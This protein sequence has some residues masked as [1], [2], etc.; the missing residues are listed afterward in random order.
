LVEKKAD[1]ESSGRPAT[2]RTSEIPLHEIPC[3]GTTVDDLLAAAEGQTDEMALLREERKWRDR[4]VALAMP[5]MALLML[6][7]GIVLLFPLR[8]TIFST[9]SG[10]GSWLGLAEHPRAILG[11][12]DLVLALLL[13]LAVTTVYPILRLRL[14]AGLGYLGYFAY[15]EWA[16]GRATGLAEIF[17]LAVFSA[18]VFVCTI[19]S[20]FAVMLVSG[21]AALAA[22]AILGAL[23]NLPGIA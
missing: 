1:P 19:T 7:S 12:L 10:S 21:L 2:P 9:I 3:S 11:A 18:G 16:A 23:W 13:G 20:R 5:L 6:I 4:A 14:M 8:N 15:A 22:I 17:L